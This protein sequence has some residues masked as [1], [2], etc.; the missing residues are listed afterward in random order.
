MNLDIA[1]F[2]CY[3]YALDYFIICWRSMFTLNPSVDINE[4]EIRL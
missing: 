1:F 2:V 3:F 4:T